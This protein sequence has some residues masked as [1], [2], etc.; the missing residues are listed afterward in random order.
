MGYYIDI[1]KSFTIILLVTTIPAIAIL[2]LV[3]YFSV[4]ANAE[5]VLI[6]TGQNL[7]L[8]VASLGSTLVHFLYGPCCYCVFR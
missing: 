5:F 1:I 6:T 4:S 2:V 7:V 3:Y 8:F